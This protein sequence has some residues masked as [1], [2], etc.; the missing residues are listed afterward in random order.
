M[1]MHLEEGLE[2]I[3][4]S[5]FSSHASMSYEHSTRSG[6]PLAP[7]STARA[8]G[9][10]VYSRSHV[11]ILSGAATSA[12]PGAVRSRVCQPTDRREYSCKNSIIALTFPWYNS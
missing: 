1:V 2:P 9:S 8:A 10:N 12:T 3:G 6:S 11:L 7:S 4:K 5:R